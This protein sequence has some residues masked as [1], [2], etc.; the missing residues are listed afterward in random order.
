MPWEAPHELW[1]DLLPKVHNV[2]LCTYGESVA[3]TR[4]SVKFQRSVYWRNMLGVFQRK[5]KGVI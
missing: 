4:V 2:P 1:L 5:E 3:L